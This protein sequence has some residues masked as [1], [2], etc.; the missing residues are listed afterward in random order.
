MFDQEAKQILW[1][2]L[3]R[4]DRDEALA[5]ILEAYEREIQKTKNPAS[6]EVPGLCRNSTDVD[7]AIITFLRKMEKEYPADGPDAPYIKSWFKCNIDQLT[8]P[9]G[10]E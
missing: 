6:G 9:K 3:D 10:D 7:E 2:Y 8:P 4:Y 1:K 5:A